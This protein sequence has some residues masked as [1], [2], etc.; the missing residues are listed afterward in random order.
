MAPS[1]PALAT[2]SM[3]T[4]LKPHTTASV[5]CYV[6]GVISK[7][8]TAT[9]AAATTHTYTHTRARAMHEVA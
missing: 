7:E 9:A 3:E 5:Y 8:A 1:R 4:Y 6:S 2:P